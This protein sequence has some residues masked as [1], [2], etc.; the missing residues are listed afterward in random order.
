MPEEKLQRALRK[1][2]AR[3]VNEVF[4]TLVRAAERGNPIGPVR[5]ET[6]TGAA[7]TG[8]ILSGHWQGGALTAAL[9]QLMGVNSSPEGAVTYL[10]PENIASLTVLDATLAVEHLGFGDTDALDLREAPTKFT[11]QRAIQKATDELNH[12]WN[13][14]LK[15]Q[16]ETTDFPWTDG[17]CLTGLADFCDVLK[18][19]FTMLLAD[20]LAKETIERQVKTVRIVADSVQNVT[21]ENHTLH[22]RIHF[23]AAFPERF[24]DQ[25]LTQMIGKIF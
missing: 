23:S 24:N 3:P 17:R 8:C 4:Q 16:F 5:L 13:G 18:K 12:D 6:R 7:V 9:L 25:K 10:N 21:F 11:V 19:S 1:L 20:S 14:K 22:L 15:F 2:P